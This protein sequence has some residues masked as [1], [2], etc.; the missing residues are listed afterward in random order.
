MDPLI[1]TALMFGSMLLLMA[2]GVRLVYALGVVGL[3]FGL[4]L[5]GPAALELP[6]VATMSIVRSFILAALPLFLFMGFIL[7]ES[8]IA[9]H[10]FETIHKWAGGIRGG[11]GIGTVAICALMAAMVGV[12]GAAT[13]SM[14]IIALPA[15][16]KRNYD[17]RIAVGL[18]MAGGALGFLIPPSIMMIMFAFISGVS[19][20]KLFAGGVIPGLMLAIMYMIY[21][22]VRC[23]LQPEIGPALPKEERATWREKFIALRGVV[24][25]GLLI[26]TVLGFIFLGITSTTEASAVGAVG[27][28]ICA[29]IYRKLNWDLVKKAGFTTLKVS[30]M[31]IWIIMGAL[32]FS[33]VYTGLGA[34]QML[35]DILSGLAIGPWGILI[36][37]QLSFFILGM[38]LDDAGILFICMPIYVPV[39]RSLGFD[40]VWFAILY[41][42]N[43]QMAYLTPPYGFNLFYMRAVAP[44]DITM[45]DIYRSVIPFVALQAVGL[46]VIM[47]IPQIALFLPGL[48]FG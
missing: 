22:G 15:M 4:W 1:I 37:M 47:I 29:A 18:V 48:I 10:L 39:I 16:R 34:T 13:V 7:Q 6:Y 8:G 2:L 36:I 31:V 44:P 19:A 14:G 40:P 11:L 3:G 23:F 45:G 26:F 41:V 24:L 27:A 46:V 33:K 35:Q 38:F 5:W 28:L 32:T 25:P 9:D 12:T 20:G 30:G 21:I 43:M 17:K 42:V